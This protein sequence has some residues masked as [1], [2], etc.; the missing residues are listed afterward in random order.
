MGASLVE[1]WLAAGSYKQWQSE[2]DIHAARSPSPHGF[3]RVYSNSV[4]S[5]NA[6]G[7]GAWPVGAAAV[8]ELYAAVT[9][10]TPVGYAVYLKTQADSA[11]G[12]NWYFYERVPLSS[13]VPHDANGVVADGLGATGTANSI[14]VACHAAAGSDAAHTPSIGGRDE[15]YTAVGSPPPDAST[16]DSSVGTA[17]TPPV[18]ASA[19]ETW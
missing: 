10:T 1:A 16:L 18:G 4:I 5:M 13:G 9:D 8:K 11:A 12:A 19:V 14:C 2:P 17:Q 6:A 3:D 7:T 15:V